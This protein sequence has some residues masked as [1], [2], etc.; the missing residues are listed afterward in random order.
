MWTAGDT[1]AAMASRLVLT[2]TVWVFATA[3]FGPAHMQTTWA[4]IFILM[5]AS[6][7]VVLK[8][9]PLTGTGLSHTPGWDVY[10]FA[11]AFLSLCRHL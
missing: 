10:A 7:P 2:V 9:N 8:T 1:T 4:S 3:S 11:L 6:L 5:I